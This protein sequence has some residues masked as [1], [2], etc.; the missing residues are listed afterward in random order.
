MPSL[1]QTPPPL[2]D[3]VFEAL[4]GVLSVAADDSASDDVLATLQALHAARPDWPE[5]SIALAQRHLLAG[6]LQPAREALEG[7]ERHADRVPLVGALLA[8][9]LHAQKDPAW[10][11]RAFE[12]ERAAQDELGSSILAGLREEVAA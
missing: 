5:L 9:T 4:V 12:A 7:V 6:D 8:Y 11:L 3:E 2:T 1:S 10:R